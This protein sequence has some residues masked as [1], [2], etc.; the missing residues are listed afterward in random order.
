MAK[1]INNSPYDDSTR[2]KLEI[3]RECF[4]EWFP[5]FINNPWADEIVIFD[6]FAGSGK[7]SAGIYGSPLVLIEE[8]KGINRRFCGNSR[9][10]ILFSFN[11]SQVRKAKQLEQNVAEHVRECE[12]LHSCGGCVYNYD[13]S[14]N[15]FK[16]LFHN[17]KTK[18]ILENRKIGKFILLDQYGFSQIDDEIFQ[19]LISY[20][21]T[22]FIFFISSSFIKRFQ[23]HPSVKAYINTEKISFDETKPKECHRVIADYFR[24]SVASDKEYYLHHFSIQKEVGK[25]NYYGLIFGSNHTLGMEKFLK[26]CW[27]KDKFSGEANFNINDDFEQGTLFF[28]VETSNKKQKVECAV[29]ESVLNG[30]IKNNIEGFK[31]V[32]RNGC[33]PILFTSVVKEL[34]EQGKISRSGELNYSSTNIH[35]I[36]KYEIHLK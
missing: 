16:T 36:K 24:K 29:Q 28:N 11:E 27:Q 8:A 18:A 20:P 34:E 30:H 1:N 33:E 22:D 3:F 14:R 35:R 13:V 2:L 12:S 9:K 23:E 19:K 32:I 5:V 15:E 7:D 4:K 26:V 21:S 6:F 10:P 31:Y 25:G 17:E